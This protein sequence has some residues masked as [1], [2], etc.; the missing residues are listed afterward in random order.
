[1]GRIGLLEILVG[2]ALVIIIFFCLLLLVESMLI[3]RQ[4]LLEQLN[5]VGDV[6]MDPSIELGFGLNEKR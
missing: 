3:L 2:I 5:G 6:R 4:Y 1:M